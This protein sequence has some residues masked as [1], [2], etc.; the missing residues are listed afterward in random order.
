MWD[1]SYCLVG[2]IARFLLA[3]A[4]GTTWVNVFAVD[5]SPAGVWRTLN[6]KTGKV[7]GTVLVYE[8]RGEFFAKVHSVVDPKEAAD[9]CD[10][11]PGELKNH[12]VIGL[13][14]MRGMKRVGTEY[15]GGEVLD[16]DTGTIYRGKFKITDSGTKMVLRGF[17]G[18]SL[19]GRS[20]T[21]L[22]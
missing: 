15:A 20:Q 2:S 9:I 22:R 19:L 16:P 21:W 11:C 8:E 12:P 4:L 18:I 1:W 6:E 10:L 17:V 3:C 5:L 14:I 7:R 13:V